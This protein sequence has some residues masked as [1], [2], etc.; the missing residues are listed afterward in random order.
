ML[1]GA[2]II[3]DEVTFQIFFRHLDVGLP[4]ICFPEYR[5]SEVDGLLS[6]QRK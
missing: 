5:T 6:L 2:N 3:L 1:P 4:Q